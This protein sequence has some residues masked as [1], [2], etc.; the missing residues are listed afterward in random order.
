MSEHKARLSAATTKNL[1]HL[2]ASVISDQK[3]YNVPSVCV[4]Y[5]LAEGTN[6]EAFSSKYKYVMQR[7]QSLPAEEVLKIARA[8]QDDEGHHDLGEALAK[9]DEESGPRITP[10]TRHRVVAELDKMRLAGALD[11]IDLLRKFWPID[12]MPSPSPRFDENQMV[13]YLRRHIFLNDDLDNVQVLELLGIYDCSQAKFFQLLEAVLD[14]LTR[15]IPEQ[16]DLATRLNR[17]LA[18]DGFRL[19]EA[20]KMSGSPIYKVRYFGSAGSTPADG[21]IAKALHAFNPDEI[22]ARW[23]EALARRAA[24]PRA[25]ITLAR[26]L[27]EDACK[28]LLHEANESF[29]DDDDLPVLYRRLA[30]V[31]KLAPDDHTEQVFKRILGSC[32]SIVESIGSIRNKLG[33]AHSQGPKRA[34]PQPRHAE[35]AVNLAGTMATFLIAT[36]DA[37]QQANPKPHKVGHDG[38][39]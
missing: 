38:G 24:D 16:A 8:L 32:Q 1:R 6:E 9:I 28:W 15:E 39:T 4:R 14:P 27:L 33:D 35:L 19:N 11:D 22:A 18:H 29:K 25:A 21:E 36:W 3:A 26:T 37:R 7:V 12:T 31:L 17:H 23:Q 5:G 10:L 30:K 34:R 20:G 13:D 2:I